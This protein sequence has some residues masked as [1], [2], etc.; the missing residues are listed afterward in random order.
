MRLKSRRR[1]EPEPE[2][3]RDKKRHAAEKRLRDE[4]GL[5]TRFSSAVAQS[6]CSP[7]T[8]RICAAMSAGEEPRA[9]QPVQRS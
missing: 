3:R 5:K 6:V 4:T 9:V 1:T 2:K 7:Y 8:S